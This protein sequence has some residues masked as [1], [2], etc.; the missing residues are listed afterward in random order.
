MPDININQI[1]EAL[2]DKM[3]RDAQNIESPTAIVIDTY[4]SGT[5]W[6]RIYSDGWCEQGGYCET[7]GDGVKTNS[8]L[9]AF[10]SNVYTIVLTQ[11]STTTQMNNTAAGSLWITAKTSTTFSVADDLWGNGCHWYACGYIPVE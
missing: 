7:T 1:G 9:I 8:L 6:Y 4:T 3:D 11:E 5:N 10:N 2:N